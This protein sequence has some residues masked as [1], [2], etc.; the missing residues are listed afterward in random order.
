MSGNVV[1]GGATCSPG[2]CCARIITFFGFGGACSGA[3]DGGPGGPEGG[4]CPAGS[5]P[6]NGECC[7]GEESM[8]CSDSAAECADGGT[9]QL[10]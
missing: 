2:Q 3:G 9:R 10:E 7:Q 5:Y 1:C 6:R 8:E 4:V